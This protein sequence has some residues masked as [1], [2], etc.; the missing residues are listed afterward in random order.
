MNWLPIY[1]LSDRLTATGRHDM[2]SWA[3]SSFD[4]VTGDEVQ[5]KYLRVAIFISTSNVTDCST[6]SPHQKQTILHKESNINY[7]NQVRMNKCW[8]SNLVKLRT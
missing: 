7:I 2:T 3:T 6:V 8:P 4:K 1:D 5:Q